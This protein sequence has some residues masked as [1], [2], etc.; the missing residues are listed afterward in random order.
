MDNDVTNFTMSAYLPLLMVALIFAMLS[1]FLILIYI[2][3]GMMNFNDIYFIFLAVKA[4]NLWS[5][6][7]CSILSVV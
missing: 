7:Q 3:V 4:F 6:S 1:G 5:G 2:L